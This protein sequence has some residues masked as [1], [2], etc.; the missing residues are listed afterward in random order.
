[1]RILSAY[2]YSKGS[3][4]RRKQFRQFSKFA[5]TVNPEEGA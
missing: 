4:Q 5:I 2:F 3:Y 1:M